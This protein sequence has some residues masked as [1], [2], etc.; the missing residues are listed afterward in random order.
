MPICAILTGYSVN[1]VARN[2]LTAAE[3]GKQV[4]KIKTNTLFGLQ[5]LANIKVLEKRIAVVVV[6]KVGYD[7]IIK[8]QYLFFVGITSGTN[9]VSKFFRLCVPQGISAVGKIRS[10]RFVDEI[11][12]EEQKYYNKCC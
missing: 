10:L 9:F 5:C 3:R 1:S 12:R 7:P 11:L 6:L 8:S 4:S 2:I